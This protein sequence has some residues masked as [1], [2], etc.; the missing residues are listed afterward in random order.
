MDEIIKILK[1]DPEEYYSIRH[2]FTVYFP[3]F[4]R[5]TYKLIELSKTDSID[6]DNL[7]GFMILLDEIEQYLEFIKSQINKS[8]RISLNVEMKALTQSLEAERKKVEK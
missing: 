4:K 3:E 8:D 6:K 1:E 5:M 7:D 2:T